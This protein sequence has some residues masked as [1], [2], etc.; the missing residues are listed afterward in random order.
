MTRISVAVLDLAGTTAREDGVVE[1]A[2]RAVV[3]TVTDGGA[4]PDLAERFHAAR[5]GSK[6]DMLRSVL[7]GDEGL[8]R[9]AHHLFEQDL[10]HRIESGHVTPMPGAAETFAGLRHRGIRTALTTGFSPAIR[11]RLLDVLGWRELVD[12][13]LSPDDA[14]RGRPHPDLIWTAA[15]RL[16]AESA[17]H[18]AV[19]GDTGN[20]LLAGTRAGAG[21]VAGVLTGAH[22]RERLQ[23]APHT[24]IL[25]G[26]G[27]LVPLI[28]SH[29]ESVLASPA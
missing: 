6:I 17:Q 5:G 21:I 3:H 24:H 10:L 4:P 12:L 1:A 26:V 16:R 11:D 23:K 27:D 20:D 18:I 2:V 13:A 28:D 29:N 8:A 19:A 25:D 14:G 22:G 9:R 15:L 7:G